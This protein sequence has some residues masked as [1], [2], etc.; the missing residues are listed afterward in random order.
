MAMPFDDVDPVWRYARQFGQIDFQLLRPRFLV[1]ANRRRCGDEP[2]LI[3][4][5]AKCMQYAAQQQCQFCRL[6]A[7]VIVCFVEHDPLQFALGFF[8]NRR[9][10]SAHQHILEHRRISHQDGRR[11]CAQRGSVQNFVRRLMLPIG[12]CLIGCHAVIKTEPNVLSERPS[13]SPQTFALA[14][15]QGIQRVKK[16]RPYS[17]KRCSFT[18]F[19]CQLAQDGHHETFS[20]ARACATGHD[21]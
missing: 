3:R 15:N 9:I 16:Q 18:A 21:D 4:T 7:Y 1:A 11:R 17:N 2:D 5:H 12:L 8:Q 19:R 14:L 20:L 13:P 10:L 6:R